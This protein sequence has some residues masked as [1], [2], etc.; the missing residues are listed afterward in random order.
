MYMQ[1]GYENK[2]YTNVSNPHWKKIYCNG[3][4]M[5]VEAKQKKTGK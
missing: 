1:V 5:T 3:K 2:K 4:L